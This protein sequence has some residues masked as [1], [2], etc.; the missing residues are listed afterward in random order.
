[1]IKN[2]SVYGCGYVGATIGFLLSKTHQVNFFDTDPKKVDLINKRFAPIRDKHLSK[3]IDNNQDLAIDAY[4]FPNFKT[5]DLHLIAVSTDYNESNGCFNTKKVE[6]VI[7]FVTKNEKQ[8]L[9][10]IKS[11]VPVGF[12]DLMQKK[13]K[14]ANIIFS[15]EFLREENAI[16]DNLNPS[17][18]IIG[19]DSKHGI[20]I[21][22]IFLNISNNDPRVIFMSSIEAESLKLFANT[23]LAMRVAFFNELDTFSIM[24]K[25]DVKKIIDGISADGRIGNYYNNPSFGYGGYC[26]PKDSKQLLANYE[27]IPQNLIQAIVDSNDTRKKF[28]VEQILLE[29]KGNIGIYKLDMKKDSTNSRSAAIIDIISMLKS[30]NKKIVIFDTQTVDIFKNDKQISATDDIEIFFKSVDM[31]IANRLDKALINH[32]DKLI[33]SR[34]IFN[35]N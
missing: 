34:D 23:Y 4:T 29:N 35:E 2:I 5:S 3:Y 14:N 15:P 30:A 24:K 13:Y 1:M 11:T 25:L 26:L 33:F 7:K 31:I 27:N 8:P 32:K 9:I 19:Q 10:L 21:S 22:K 28:I 20:E 12:T 18:I 6:E 17:R 16:E